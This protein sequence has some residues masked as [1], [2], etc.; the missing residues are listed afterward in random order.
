MNSFF[1][2][3]NRRKLS[4]QKEKSQ[5]SQK[6]KDKRNDTTDDNT[7][8]NTIS[9]ETAVNTPIS[10]INIKE[11]KYSKC[12]SQEDKTFKCSP[13]DNKNVKGKYL[14]LAESRI[15]KR[16][17][18]IYKLLDVGYPE[19]NRDALDK[20]G[21]FHIKSP[22]TCNPSPYITDDI[23]TNCTISNNSLVPIGLIMILNDGGKN[24]D[25][26]SNKC[27]GISK[28]SMKNS[29]VQL[30]IKWFWVRCHD[31]FYGLYIFNKNG[32]MHYNIYPSHIL[33]K[34]NELKPD[35]CKMYL[36]DYSK[37]R[38]RSDII[39][40]IQNEETNFPENTDLTDY[41]F[42]QLYYYPIETFLL[43]N[44]EFKAFIELTTTD[45]DTMIEN[46]TEDILVN[47]AYTPK[48]NKN[49]YAKSFFDTLF[50]FMQY[51]M[52]AKT[53]LNNFT[54]YIK[55]FTEFLTTIVEEGKRDK[56]VCYT[57]LLELNL[58]SFD[59]YGFG[60]SM[61]CVL[62]RSFH[63]I[64]NKLLITLNDFCYELINPNVFKRNTNILTIMIKYEEILYQFGLLDSL[65]RYYDKHIL[66]IGTKV[67]D[68]FLLPMQKPDSVKRQM[69]V[70]KEINII[71]GKA[72]NSAM[73]PK[74]RYTVIFNYIKYVLPVI[75]QYF[76]RIRP[77]DPVETQLINYYNNRY[78]KTKIQSDIM[79]SNVDTF[80]NTLA[81]DP[82][83][84]KQYESL[85]VDLQ[86]YEKIT[87]Q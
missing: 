32:L 25:D 36:I 9:M 13:A 43:N 39:Y 60:L 7:D 29:D 38:N 82:E 57:K 28:D 86:G 42:L 59:T 24:L 69:P 15:I 11:T 65:N 33:F 46:L 73:I 6:S 12:V 74:E 72:T 52:I 66:T 58:K 37:T 26:Y 83:L 49:Y 67:N 81:R 75:I 79:T 48:N 51:T 23:K 62:K 78:P 63:L 56:N 19:Q 55:D 18:E 20:D 71:D 53:D 17:L 3:S 50:P 85:V 41:P 27:I 8:D 16:E 61:L 10:L 84:A 45:I 34:Y 44:T 70:K 35:E 4:K 22:D 40:F 77:M 68:P 47:S 54:R 30:E 2:F 64:D 87:K 14:K 1:S 5:K 80:V 76:L 31:I 21:I